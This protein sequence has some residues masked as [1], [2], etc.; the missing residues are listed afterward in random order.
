MVGSEVLGGRYA[1]FSGGLL[2]P[3]TSKNQMTTPTNQIV[4]YT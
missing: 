1:I 3:E 2:P 4:D